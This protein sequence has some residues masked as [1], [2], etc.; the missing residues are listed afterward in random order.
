MSRVYGCYMKLPQDEARTR[1]LAS[2]VAR[3]ATVSST[4]TPHLVPVTF[5]ADGEMIYFAIDHKPKSSMDLRRLRNI[6]E[7]SQVS[8]LVDHYADDWSALWWARADGEAE[9]WESD[10]RQPAALELLVAKYPQY[11]QRSP[12]GPVV[13]IKVGRWSGW[14]FEG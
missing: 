10:A 11:R 7:N 14:A 12:H 2:S 9:I 6:R 1:L 8:L 5:A 13:A 4:G 3:L